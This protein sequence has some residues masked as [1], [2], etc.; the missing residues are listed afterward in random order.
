MHQISI[1]KACLL[2][3]VVLSLALAGQENIWGDCPPCYND[4]TPL[5]GHGAAPDG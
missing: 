2:F 3:A 1:K 5:A 4:L